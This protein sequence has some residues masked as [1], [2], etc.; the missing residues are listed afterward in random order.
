MNTFG[1]NWTIDKMEIVVSYTKAYLTIMNKQNWVKTIYFDGF[2]GS[3]YIRQD[4]NS[5]EPVNDLV[6]LDFSKEVK[7]E[8]AVKGAALRILEI[9]DPRPFD[10][11]YFVE[12]NKNNK[13]TLEQ[14]IKNVYPNKER[15][16]VVVEEDCNTKL[17]DMQLS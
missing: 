9:S 15:K 10:L 6:A 17:K 5:D 4:E 1:G 2:A 3:G 11:Y 12:K 13:T 14:T 8:E 7:G 16:T